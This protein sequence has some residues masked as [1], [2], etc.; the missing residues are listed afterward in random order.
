MQPSFEQ[1]FPVLYRGWGEKEA[2]ADFD[3]GGWK[4]KAGAD[5]FLNSNSTS[6]G[7]KSAQQI[8]DDIM[9]AQEEQVKRETQFLDQYTKDNPFVFDEALAKESSKAEYSPYYTELL[10]KYL[11]DIGVNRDS[12][13]SEQKLLTALTSTPSG[14]AGQAERQYQ[15]AIE[16][17]KQGFAESGTFF[18]GT[19]ARKLGQAEVERAYGLKSETTDIMRKQTDV[20]REQ[21]AAIES[22]VLQRQGETQKAYYTPLEQ[23]YF[24]QFPS[25]GANVLRGYVPSDYMRL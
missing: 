4:N 11:Q 9:K 7:Q 6:T 17:A 15:R 22:G 3:T 10:D 8:V 21:E 2:R 24:R 1:V 19:A 16:T 5:Q 20:G 25:S 12:L 13:Q 14:T 23:S 18:S